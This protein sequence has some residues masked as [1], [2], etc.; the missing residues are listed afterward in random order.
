MC[1]VCDSDCLGVVVILLLNVM[2]L[3]SVVA[4][5]LLDRPC[6]SSKKCV[7][8]ACDPSVRLDAPST[9]FVCVFCMSE[10]YLLI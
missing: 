1:C 6:Y 7:Y 9:W 3:V 2:E 4:G 10:S 5:A 8:C